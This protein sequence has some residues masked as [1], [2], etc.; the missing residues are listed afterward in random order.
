MQWTRAAERPADGSFGGL[1]AIIYIGTYPS[2]VTGLV[3]EDAALP[4]DAEID[5]ILPEPDCT[6]VKKELA[7]K[8]LPASAL[9]R[10][11]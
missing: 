11:D 9:E 3:M 8:G 7:N 4:A 6:Q 2:E 1:I 5:D 10:R